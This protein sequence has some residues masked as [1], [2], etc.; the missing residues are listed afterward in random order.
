M[1][2]C[3]KIDS[4]IVGR[5]ALGPKQLKKLDVSGIYKL[6][7]VH[8]EQI[9]EYLPDCK[10]IFTELSKFVSFD[11]NIKIEGNSVF[12]SKGVNK[13]VR[14][15]TTI[16]TNQK[17]FYFEILIESEGENNKIGIGIAGESHDL[18]GMPGWWG[19]SYGFHGDDG[20][21]F[22]GSN[23]GASNK[24]LQKYGIY[25]RIG[26]GYDLDN[27]C[28]FF[29]KNG[30][31]L[32]ICFY[33]V[34]NEEFYAVVGCMSHGARFSFYFE[35]GNFLFDVDQYKFEKSKSLIFLQN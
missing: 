29:T 14:S 20:K 21:I 5:F 12:Y 35:K 8:I 24:F 26:L 4:K 27:K 32:G 7:S 31:F 23:S 34:P 33:D 3:T 16:P 1:E 6:K 15:N 17:L 19:S 2:G 28:I 9:K 30:N 18:N 10:V 13:M 22:H 11:K 25:D